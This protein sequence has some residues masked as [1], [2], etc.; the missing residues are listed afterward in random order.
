MVINP[1][2]SHAAAAAAD[3]PPERL[4][5]NSALTEQEKIA[6]ASRQFEAILLRQILANIQKTVIPSKLA[7]NSTAAGIYRDMISNQLADSIS[8][9]GAFGLAK[10]FEHQLSPQA[11]SRHSGQATSLPTPKNF[12]AGTPDPA[13][14]PALLSPHAA[15]DRPRKLPTT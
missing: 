1:L 14:R 12:P 5:H 10:T 8:K 11:G 7:D 9:S 6:E 15:A 13:H 3:L 4:V 2:P